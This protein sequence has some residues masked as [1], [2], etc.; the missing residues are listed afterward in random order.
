MQWMSLCKSIAYGYGASMGKVFRY[1]CALNST[2][3]FSGM[4][5]RAQRTL[6]SLLRI[7]HCRSGR[8]RALKMMLFKMQ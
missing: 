1:V 5:K 8:E 6:G 7:A 4:K 3:A 2:T